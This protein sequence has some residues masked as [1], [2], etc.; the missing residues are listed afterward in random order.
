MKR[1]QRDVRHADLVKSLTDAVF[2][3]IWRLITFAAVLGFQH[4]VRTPI[5]NPD[6]GK[7]INIDSFSSPN[8]K[9]LL[10]LMSVVETGNSS[11]LAGTN[12]SDDHLVKIFEE[13]ANGG[14]D[15]IDK[16]L[17][18][19]SDPVTAIVNLLLEAN[20][21]PKPSPDVTGLI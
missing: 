10:Y 3:E 1:V 16:Q 18:S 14:L 4:G 6:S 9:G 13:Y 15:I 12:D 8:W 17:R 2:S 5:S 19:H 11:C 20:Q 21:S 7:S